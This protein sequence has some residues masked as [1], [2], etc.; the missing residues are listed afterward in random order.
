VGGRSAARGDARTGSLHRRAH[1]PRTRRAQRAARRA[2]PLRRR[3]D[4]ASW[5]W[6]GG[7]ACCARRGRPARPCCS[8]CRCGTAP[9]PWPV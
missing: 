7:F 5:S 2:L 4:P 6:L 3:P 9:A 8:Q 1:R